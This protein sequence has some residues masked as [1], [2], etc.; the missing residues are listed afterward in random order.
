MRQKEAYQNDE[1]FELFT[2]ADKNGDKILDLDGI[3]QA[4]EIY[5]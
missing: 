4:N 2:S 3:I 5:F 1:L